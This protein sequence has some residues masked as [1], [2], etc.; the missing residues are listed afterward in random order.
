MRRIGSQAPVQNII[1][2][3]VT[4]QLIKK[5]Q[6]SQLSSCQWDRAI[7][8]I[9]MENVLNPLDM[10]SNASDVGDGTE[11]VSVLL[12]KNHLRLTNNQGNQR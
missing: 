7:D 4:K 2:C 9:E 11:P 10:I 1:E 3:H 8:T 12:E 5:S 6:D